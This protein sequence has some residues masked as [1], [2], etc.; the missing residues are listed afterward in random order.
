[1]EVFSNSSLMPQSFEDKAVTSCYSFECM[2]TLVCGYKMC[3]F[4]W[5]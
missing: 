4:S 1:M 5:A 2:K 3:V